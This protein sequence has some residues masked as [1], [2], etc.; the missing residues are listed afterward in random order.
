MPYYP[1]ATGGGTTVT[2]VNVLPLTA[3]NGDMVVLTTDNVLYIYDNGFWAQVSALPYALVA[4]NDDFILT[5]D[6]NNLV[7]ENNA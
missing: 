7:V 2:F 1:P 6:N 3:T 4:E 5:E